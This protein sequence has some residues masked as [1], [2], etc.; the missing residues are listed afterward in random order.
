MQFSFLHTCKHKKEDTGLQSISLQQT[1]V[2]TCN[3]EP[4]PLAGIRFNLSP[5]EKY[6]TSTCTVIQSNKITFIWLFFCLPLHI[7]RWPSINLYIY[8]WFHFQF[9]FM[10]DSLSYR[11]TT[12]DP[13]QKHGMWL[14]A[15]Q[16]LGWLV[17]WWMPSSLP[18]FFHI[19][20]YICLHLH[21][22][23][24]HLCMLK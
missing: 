18:S 14:S 17:S 9:A 4:H 16:S 13:G 20:L 23:E 24:C 6:D 15:Q 12:T 1:Q 21:N 8:N 19:V 11:N 2:V 3:Q 22:K 5:P 7:A 10:T